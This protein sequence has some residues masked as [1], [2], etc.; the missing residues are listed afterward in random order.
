M[1]YLKTK[2]DVP[3]DEQCDY[4]QQKKLTAYWN[5]QAHNGL[6][7]NEVDSLVWTCKNL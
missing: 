3:I 2:S 1:D 7:F 4:I 5:S 6:R